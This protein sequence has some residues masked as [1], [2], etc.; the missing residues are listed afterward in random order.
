MGG[1]ASKFFSGAGRALLGVGKTALNVIPAAM[2]GAQAGS[3]AGPWGAAAGAMAMALPGTITG[4]TDT[5]NSVRNPHGPQSFRELLGEA[6]SGAMN[7]ANRALSDPDVVGAIGQGA[8]TL[9][10]TIGGVRGGQSWRGAWHANGGNYLGAAT[11]QMLSAKLS[12]RSSGMTGVPSTTAMMLGNPFLLST[13]KMSRSSV[14][15]SLHDNAVLGY[16]RALGGRLV[17]GMG[18][19]PLGDAIRPRGGGGGDPAA[20]GAG[21]MGGGGGSVMGSSGAAAGGAGSFDLKR[22]RLGA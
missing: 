9:A 1:N 12:N 10:G 19:G 18:G 5:I 16:G 4:L 11:A 6:G 15:R 7:F 21:G 2:Q 17:G 22:P 20:A 8:Q 14:G 3:K 13:A